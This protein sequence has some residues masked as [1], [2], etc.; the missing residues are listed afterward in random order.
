MIPN[1]NHCQ[2]PFSMRDARG[3]RGFSGTRIGVALG[4]LA[5]VA[6][7]AGRDPDDERVVGDVVRDD[8]AGPDKGAL[9]ID[10]AGD[11]G[12]IR[13]DRGTALDQRRRQFPVVVGLQAAIGI[14]GAGEEIVGEHHAVADEHLVLD[15][16][17]FADEGVRRDLA[18]ATDRAFFWISTKGP[19]RLPLP[20]VHL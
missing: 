4:V 20:I 2:A 8:R 16:H 1:P 19:T 12:G 10:D 17:A 18:V 5:G 14:G 15:G 13:A 3:C 6:D 9:P 11:D 7:D